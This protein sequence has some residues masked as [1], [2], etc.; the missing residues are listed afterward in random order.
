[1]FTDIVGFTNISAKDGNKAL[2]LLDKQRFLNDNILIVNIISD[3]DRL[4]H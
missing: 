4:T 3:W 2:A 1:M